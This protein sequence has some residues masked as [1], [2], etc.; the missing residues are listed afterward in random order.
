M[1]RILFLN[2]MVIGLAAVVAGAAGTLAYF[3]DNAT[4]SSNTFTAGTLNVVLQNGGS[5]S[6][7]D[8][9]S[10]T[11]TTPAGWAPGNTY[12][13]VLK[14]ANVGSVPAHS[15]LIDFQNGGCTGAN[16]FEKIQVTSYQESWDGG[17]TWDPTDNAPGLVGVFD[18][19]GPGKFG[20]GDGKLSLWE[21]I[22]GDS[23]TPGGQSP[24]PY[25]LAMYAPA[26]GRSVPSQTGDHGAW[27]RDD[28]V[29]PFNNP[30]ILPANGSG[31][32]Y[33][34]RLTFKFMEDAGNAYQ[35][36]SCVMN[37]ATKFVQVPGGRPWTSLAGY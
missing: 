3:S 37:V 28:D 26:D 13:Q 31:P 9:V 8:D 23:T 12:T 36:D 16:M 20:N 15:G 27:G 4:S 2:L 19:T 33:A 7:T 6:W 10:G 24:S 11:W 1:R 25:D 30:D 18:L 29:L 32:Q 34:M 5:G 21:L 14:F 17:A 22:N 35:N